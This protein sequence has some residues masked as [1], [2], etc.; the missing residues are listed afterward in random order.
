[1]PFYGQFFLAK[2]DIPKPDY[3]VTKSFSNWIVGHHPELPVHP[4]KA[5]DDNPVGFMI[6]HPIVDDVLLVDST[7]IRLAPNAAGLLADIDGAHRNVA[8]RYVFV[9]LQDAAGG[10]GSIPIR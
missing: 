5:S 4:V 10:G 1:M 3:F 7:P 8:G 9:L 6:G 2:K